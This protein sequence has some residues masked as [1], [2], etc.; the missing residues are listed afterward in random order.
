[1]TVKLN[2]A[3]ANA[4]AGAVTV[5]CGV[6]TWTTTPVLPRNDELP[7][8][9]AVRNCMPCVWSVNPPVGADRKT[10]TRRIVVC[11][12][13]MF[14]AQVYISGSIGTWTVA[15]SFVQRRFV[16]ISVA[17][18]TVDD[19]TVPALS[20]IPGTGFVL[21]P[22]DGFPPGRPQAVSLRGY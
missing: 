8:S 22:W 11:L 17:L 14:A 4:F 6:G 1:M 13:V 2:G 18:V 21:E 5:K 19:I 12:L 20:G 9:E 3:P 7:V 10:D 16:G 15:G